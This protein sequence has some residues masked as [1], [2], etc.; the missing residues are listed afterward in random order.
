[1]RLRRVAAYADAPP[2]LSLGNYRMLTAFIIAIIA[3]VVDLV[4][5]VMN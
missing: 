5:P 4:P 3:A 2:L 1:M